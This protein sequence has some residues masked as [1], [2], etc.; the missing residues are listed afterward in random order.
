MRVGNPAVA[1]PWHFPFSI[2]DFS[3]VIALLLQ[4]PAAIK[5]AN[6]KFKYLTFLICH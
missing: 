6:V 1:S 3:F 4:S 5:F 2:F